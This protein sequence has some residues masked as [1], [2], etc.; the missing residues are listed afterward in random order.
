V[1]A[2][3]PVAHRSGGRLEI[4]IAGLIG[5]AAVVAAYATVSAER[6]EHKATIAF[7]EGVR[8]TTAAGQAATAGNQVLQADQQLFI[9]YAAAREAGHH[10]LVRYIYDQLMSPELRA[11]VRWWLGNVRART[12]FD[13][14]D[15][16]YRI[17]AHDRAAALSRRSARLVEL[18]Q[19]KQE[20]ADSYHVV[21]VVVAGALFLLGLA[22]VLRPGPIRPTAVVLGTGVLIA[23][24][25]LLALA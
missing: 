8:A 13:P 25:V 7:H 15:P 14:A 3:A 1:H 4:V 9:Q 20:L 2:G 5:A 18:G 21:D 24:T 22:G 16:A 6:A 11:G 12:P 19:S 10:R 23:A 17:P